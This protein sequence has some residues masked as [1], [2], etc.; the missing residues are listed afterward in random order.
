MIASD[1]GT[2]RCFL[3]FSTPVPKS[4]AVNGLMKS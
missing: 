3:R 1:F 2:R 4:E